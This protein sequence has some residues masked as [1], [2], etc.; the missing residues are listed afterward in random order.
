MLGAF[1][2]FP[3]G[4]EHM[5]KTHD[6]KAVFIASLPED[7][8][9]VVNRNYLRAVL[10]RHAHFHNGLQH[11]ILRQLVVNRYNLP[12]AKG[13]APSRYDL[14][15]D[16][17]IVHTHIQF[18]HTNIRSFL[19]PGTKTIT[20]YGYVNMLLNQKQPILLIP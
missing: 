18:T 5:A 11:G 7:E 3:Q 8:P 12:Y 14:P 6:H 17:P 2:L 13:L 16:K 20:L 19:A 1:D 4:T 15:V 10:G 9:R